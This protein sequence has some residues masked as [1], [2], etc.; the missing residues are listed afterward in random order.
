[1]NKN[2]NLFVG[3]GNKDGRNNRWKRKSLRRVLNK[4]KKNKRGK[5]AGRC[6]PTGRR[7]SGAL[8]ANDL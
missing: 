4:M 2:K 7:D 6:Y 1:M 8:S 5:E 3:I